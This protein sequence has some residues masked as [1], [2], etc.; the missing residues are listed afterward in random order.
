MSAADRAVLA[1]AARQHGLVT[2]AQAGAAGWSPRTLR[3]RVAAGELVAI[4]PGVWRVAA[5]EVSFRQEVLA[6]V[7]AG[8]V[9]VASHATAAHLHALYRA[10]RP[11][12][13]EVTVERGDVSRMRAHRRETLWLPDAER[14]VVDAIPVTTAARTIVDLAAR[15][16]AR[17][18]VDVLHD[19]LRRGLV[20]RDEVVMVGHAR[21]RL[22][23]VRSLRAALDALHPSAERLESPLEVA[24]LAYLRRL[25]LPDPVLQLEVVDAGG[26]VV[27]RLDAAYP[28]RRVAVEF[29]GASFHTAPSDRRRDERRTGRLAAA[30]WEVVRLGWADLRLGPTSPVAAD[31]VQRVIG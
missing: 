16:S 31:L 4:E 24:G 3:R 21:P 2:R 30:G 13:A 10:P 8:R 7:L 19:A 14:T 29:D 1:I 17:H 18:L 6:S 22:N 28:D 27:A 5:F 25:G 15:W 9:R 23:G 11:R 12:R 26:R 20:T